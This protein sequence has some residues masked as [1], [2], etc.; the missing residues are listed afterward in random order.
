LTLLSRDELAKE[1]GF[2]W[3]KRNLLITFHPVTLENQP[4]AVQ[5]QQLLAALEQ[6]GPAIGLIFTKPNSDTDGRSLMQIIDDYIA[7]HTNA[8]AYT[9]LGQLRYLSA[10]AQVD[11]VV[12]N[13]SSGLYEAPSFKKP[14]VNIGDRQKGRLQA[15]SVI[16]C[17]PEAM[18]IAQAIQQAFEKDCSQA[19]NPYGDGNSSSRIA[20][21]L[22]EIQE[23]Q[24][25]LKKHFFEET[26]YHE[27]L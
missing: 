24:R 15:A 27:E 21:K 17:Q 9:S 11:A 4:A 18:A 23:P 3:Q 6:L 1:I 22:K 12:G 14:T 2:A 25:L 16:N 20:A 19:T 8:K 13:S 7:G 5:F 26:S 10:M